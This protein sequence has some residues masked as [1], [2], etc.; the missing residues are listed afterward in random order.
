MGTTVIGKVGNTTRG[1]WNV[2]T[3]NYEYLDIVTYEGGSYMVK[4]P[5]G[6]VPAGTLP[7][8]TTY[9]QM[10][11]ERGSV[12]WTPIHANVAD[13][14]R[15]VQQLV[16]Y[17]GGSGTKPTVNIGSYV[18]TTGYTTNIAN[19]KDVNGSVSDGVVTTEKLAANAVTADKTAFIKPGK[20]KFDL[21]KVVTSAA[22]GSAPNFSILTGQG[23]SFAYYAMDCLPNQSYAFSG[24]INNSRYSRVRFVDAAGAFISGY[25]PEPTLDVMPKIFTTP[26]LCVK[27]YINVRNGANVTYSTL[28]IEEGTAATTYSAYSPVID[29]SLIPPIDASK[30]PSTIFDNY[31]TRAIAD[32]KYLQPTLVGKNLINKTKLTPGKAINSTT[33]GIVSLS[34]WTLFQPIAVLPETLYTYSGNL[35]ADQKAIRFEDANH[36]LISF[37]PPGPTGSST[38][39]SFTTPALCAYVVLPASNTNGAANTALYLDSAQL[40]MGSVTNYQKYYKWILPDYLPKGDNYPWFG[41][42][43]T[44]FGDSITQFNR[45][46]K[47]V[48]EIT[49]VN[50]LRDS[51]AGSCIATGKEDVVGD[52][53]LRP[54]LCTRADNIDLT[55]PD[56]IFIFAGTNDCIYGVPMGTLADTATN[57]FYGGLKSMITKLQTQNPNVRIAM[58]TLCQL[59]SDRSKYALQKSYA[60]TTLEVCRYYGIPC[61]DAFGKSGITYENTTQ[62]TSDGIHPS[63]PLGD[64]L[65]GRQFAAF[66]NSL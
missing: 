12:G 60:D 20:N 9:W 40:E 8:N 59:T 44:F 14:L 42:R 55:S 39:I 58:S 61:Y 16:D 21:T 50:F 3:A 63:E 38:T 41:K 1:V 28:Q 64:R 19:A 56:F 51:V 35:G 49:G 45:Y 7:T 13:G 29:L 4:L 23:S 57:T 33:G 52:G 2:T 24:T 54:A 37:I 26:P 62:W 43:L 17:V 32:T 6:N 65:I 11:A 48:A 47:I 31:D 10:I 36:A 53:T 30:L 18:S 22:I 34:N 5:T 27:F 25:D 46:T 15:T 66:I